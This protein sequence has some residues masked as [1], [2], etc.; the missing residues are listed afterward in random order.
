MASIDAAANA[1]VLNVGGGDQMG[2]RRSASGEDLQ[3]DRI[4][5]GVTETRTIADGVTSFAQTFYKADGVTVTTDP[6]AARLIDVTLTVDLP[7]D[8]APGRTVRGRVW[9]RQW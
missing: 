8:H 1:F 3:L 9:I 7:R 5:S 2:F 6:A 4:V